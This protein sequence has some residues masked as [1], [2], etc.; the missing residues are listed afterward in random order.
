MRLV[1]TVARGIR[2]P[3]VNQGDD[4][5]TLASDSILACQAEGV[6]TIQDRDI[7]ALTE[8]VVA[9]AQGNYADVFQSGQ[10]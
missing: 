4:L 3:I 6:F 5:V 8:S 9:R 1:G 2:A 10:K 7:F